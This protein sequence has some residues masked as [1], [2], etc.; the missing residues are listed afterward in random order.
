MH[1]L[2]VLLVA[3]SLWGG[4][5][6]W[7]HERR[8]SHPPGI[9]VEAGP[10]IR[11]GETRA[12][13]QDDKGFRYASLGAFEGRAMV[14]ARRN[15]DLGEFAA[16][17]PTDLALGWGELSD[18][19]I[20]DQLA[21]PQMKSFSSRFVVPEFRRGS[22]L[23]ERP[24]PELEELFRSLTHVHTIPGDP[25]IR[26]T[27]AGIRPGQVIRFEGTLVLAVAPSG[28]RYESSLALGDRNCEI[29][30]IDDLELE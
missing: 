25:D 13:W 29:A 14:L 28:G 19:R 5:N 4:W 1:W 23:R 10:V 11:A 8:V 7:N 6:W 27:L 20:V 24:R 18:P 17:A 26:R 16:L 22:E 9:V 12:P 21:F 3:L 30:W 2:L 15:Y